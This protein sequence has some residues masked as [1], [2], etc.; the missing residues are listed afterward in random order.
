[1]LEVVFNES[2]K[3]SIKQAKSSNKTEDNYG[4][5]DN[6]AFIGGYLDIGDISGELNS[7]EGRKIFDEFWTNIYSDEKDR[8]KYFNEQVKDIDKLLEAAKK[9]GQVRIWKG[10]SSSSICGFMFVC[11]LLKDIDCKIKVVN[12]PEYI[13]RDDDVIESFTDWDSVAPDRFHK[14][15]SYERELTWIEKNMYS[16]LWEELRLENAPLRALVN[17]SLISVPEDFYDHLIIKNIPKGEFKIVELIGVVFGKYQI[18]VSDFWY[19]LRIKKMIEKGLLE[20]VSVKE[21]LWKYETILKK[22][23]VVY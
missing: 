4:D 20:V 15:L 17:G 12:L 5:F 14:F 18:G 7:I 6:I 16:G 10:N 8:D 9:N 3:A 23:T 19:V 22:K 2:T 11:S 1:M 13:V 21:P